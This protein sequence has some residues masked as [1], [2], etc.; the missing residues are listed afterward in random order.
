MILS[1]GYLFYVVCLILFDVPCKTIQTGF[2]ITKVFL[3]HNEYIVFNLQK[4][5][6]VKT[7]RTKYYKLLAHSCNVLEILLGETS[8]YLVNIKNVSVM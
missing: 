8:C 6:A 5:V 7:T 1:L 2:R 4:A 3:I